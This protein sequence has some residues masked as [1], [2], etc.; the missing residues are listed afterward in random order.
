M[1]THTMYRDMVVARVFFSEKYYINSRTSNVSSSN[2]E[3]LKHSIF[4]PNFSCCIACI[5]W[6][7]IVKIACTINIRI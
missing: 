1:N 2:V 3:S 5:F 6:Y 4:I 7:R